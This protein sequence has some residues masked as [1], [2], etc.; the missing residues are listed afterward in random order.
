MSNPNLPPLSLSILGVEPHDEF[1]REIA[2]FVHHMIMTRPDFGGAD[3]KVEV[4]AKIGVLRDKMSGRRLVLPV[5]VET[6]LVPESFDIRFESNMSKNT[7][8]HYNELLNQ[9]KISSSQ[10][11]HPSSPLE[12]AHRYLIDSFYPSDTRE[13]I[14]VTR[15]ERTGELVECVRKIRLKDLNIFSPK[16]AADWRI[17]VNLEVPVPQPSGTPTHTRR[18]DRISYSH[19]EFSIDLTQ[20]TSTASGGG[21]PEV[22]HELELEI[23]RPSLLLSTAMKR[24]DLNV[25]EHE[26]SAF[27]E[28]IR[29]FVNNARILVRNAGDGWQP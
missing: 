6:I 25:P 29:A 18:K 24:G 12:Y 3:A 1:I 11:G 17:S 2:D 10:P 23:S 19:E 5:L 15:D 26:R 8:K 13:K 9:L 22:L 4:E 21:A 14:R 16:R 28:L 27:D 7:H 20:V